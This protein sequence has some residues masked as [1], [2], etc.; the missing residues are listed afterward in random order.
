MSGVIPVVEVKS[1]NELT[2]AVISF[3]T[4]K[5]QT[6]IKAIANGTATAET[7]NSYKTDILNYIATSESVTASLL[8]PSITA[9]DDN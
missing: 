9:I 1:T 2:T 8:A 4:S 5:F 3:A 7:I 6:D